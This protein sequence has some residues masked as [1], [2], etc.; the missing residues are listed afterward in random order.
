M[1]TLPQ[2][3]V[4]KYYF[5]AVVRFNFSLTDLARGGMSLVIAGFLLTVSMTSI[6]AERISVFTEQNYPLNYTES[7]ENE[8]PIIGAATELVIAVLEE[9]G[10]EY[11][12]RI[13]PWAR[14]M[15][16]IDSAENIL[17]YSMVRS[18]AREDRYRWIGEIF[19]V[20]VYLYGLKENIDW[21]PRSLGEAADLRIGVTRGWWLHR[22]LVEIGFKRLVVARRPSV[23]LNMLKRG[24]VD[25]VPMNQL[26]AGLSG[27]RSGI[28]RNDLIAV[29]ELAELKSA[30]YMVLSKSTN[31]EIAIRL[32]DAYSRIRTSGTYHEIMA[33]L[34]ASAEEN[35]VDVV[36]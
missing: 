28:D 19:P 32:R 23:T 18:A 20:E 22:Y 31:P 33:S 10:L 17:V 25:M 36:H 2:R 35:Q 3:Q 6:G 16:A 12:I 7:G 34:L 4:R 8:G 27:E 1:R 30:T 26:R 15:Q 29:I 5:R 14:A 11:E 9:A 21:L 13:G 24:R